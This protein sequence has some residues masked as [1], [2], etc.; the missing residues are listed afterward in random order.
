MRETNQPVRLTD[1]VLDPVQAA[2]ALE[3]VAQFDPEHWA[4]G[5]L[6]QDAQGSQVDYFSREACRWAVGGFLIRE[7]SQD[8]FRRLM[9]VFDAVLAEKTDQPYRHIHWWNDAP[10][11]T[12]EEVKALLLETAA[13]LRREAAASNPPTGD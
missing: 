5:P 8:L 6:F 10:G 13:R 11:R 7:T 2:A 9:R 12:P 4:Q 3:R 1:L